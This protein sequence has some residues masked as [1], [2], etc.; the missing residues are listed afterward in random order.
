MTPYPVIIDVARPD[1]FERV[2]LL[3]RFALVLAIGYIGISLGWL[4]F[5][6]YLALPVVAAV[7]VSSLGLDRFRGEA[8]PTL[9]RVLEWIIAFYGYMLLLTDRFPT[10][11]PYGNLEVAIRPAGSPTTGSALLRLITSLPMFAAL[12]VLGFVSWLFWIIAMFAILFSERHPPSLYR[13]QRGVLRWQGR[14]LAYHASLVDAYPPFAFDT[15][16]STPPGVPAGT[17]HSVT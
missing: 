3:L 10:G 2:Q 9:A 12:F 6:L 13:F 11:A 1:R 5:A 16:R 14:L 15:G 4:M 7:A 17:A 8:A